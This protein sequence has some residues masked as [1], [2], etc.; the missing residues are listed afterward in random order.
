[1]MEEEVKK[2]KPERLIYMMTRREKIRYKR[3]MIKKKMYI[4]TE[5]QA[6][7]ENRKYS[8]GTYPKIE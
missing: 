3:E 7:K 8:A 1:M 5:K 2:F 4:D 6:I